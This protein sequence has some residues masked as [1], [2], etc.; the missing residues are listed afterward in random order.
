MIKTGSIDISKVIE[1]GPIN[2]SIIDVSCCSPDT[3]PPGGGNPPPGTQNPPSGG[4]PSTPSSPG[5]P[6]TV[7]SSAGGSVLG[8]A[9][10]SGSI[11][12]ATGNYYLMVMTILSAIL[13]FLGLRLRHHPGRDPGL[14]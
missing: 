5:G 11:L 4:T 1:N 13:F 10:D 6:S 7:T 3:N 12:P 8:A 9:T 2:T 14:S